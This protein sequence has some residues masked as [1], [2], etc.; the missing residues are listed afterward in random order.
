MTDAPSPLLPPPAVTARP[1]KPGYVQAIA[2]MC[3]V[4][5]CLNILWAAFLFLEIAVLGLGFGAAT[6]GVCCLPAIVL[7]F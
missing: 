1:P 3:L 5:G 7:Y 4:D 6:M 2:I